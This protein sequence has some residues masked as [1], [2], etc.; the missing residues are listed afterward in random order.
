MGTRLLVSASVRP[1]FLALILSLPA[2][3]PSSGPVAAPRPPAL[4]AVKP[5]LWLTDEAARPTPSLPAE[6][7]AVILLDERSTVVSPKGIVTTTCRR[8]TRVLRPG[9]VEL[10]NRLALVDTYDSKVRSMTGWVINPSG[11]PREVTMKQV[12]SSSITP[13]TLYMDAKFMLL[14]VPEVDVG[15]VVGFEWE[16]RRTQP[17]IE[18][19]YEFQG[20]LPVLR[21]CYSL[22][23][24][25]G[26]EPVF[27][28]VNWPA[29]AA[30]KRDPSA[31]GAISFEIA[32]IPAIAN[33]PYRPKDRA[34]GGRLLVRF[35]MLDA[36]LLSFADWTDMG[37]WYAALSGD[38]RLPDEAVS[39]KARELTAAAPDT[40]SKI[41]ALAEFAQKEIRYVSI[42]IGIGGLQPHPAPGVLY[43]RYGDCKDK[44][45]LLAA[46]LQA[47]GIDSHYI[48][49]HT[50]RGGVNLKSPVSLGSF[51]HVI[52]AI[53]LPDDVPDTDLDSVVRHPG[54]GRLIVFDPTMPT[55][56][57]GR[58]PYYLQDNTGL[59][60][61]GGGGELLVL[62]RP[63]P[64]GN[65]LDRRG[66]LVL[67][68]DGAL[69]GEITE[70]RRGAEADSL[71]YQIQSATEAERRKYLETFLSRS[72]ASFSLETYE[73]K[74]LEDAR[75][76]LVVSYSFI[77]SAYAKRAG[78]YLVVRP[79]VVGNKAV[80]LASRDKKPRRYPIDL[81]TTSFSQDEFTIELPVGWTADSLPK[82]VALDAGFASY[83]SRTEAAGPTLVY[84]RE[85]R[86]IDPLLPA[87]RHEEALKFFLA[88]GAEE[89][90][91]LLL[92]ATVIRRP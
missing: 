88:V 76:D 84:R 38:R 24:P 90:Q 79:R 80:D 64:G 55:T 13:D 85:Y 49:I 16:E 19:I 77:A 57:L 51:N 44:A 30:S 67:T 9:G 29:V 23:A 48:I 47:V 34:L 83:S 92:K 4:G 78:G 40:F 91:S 42:Q 43:N 27:S 56:P 32:D 10:A 60:V 37:A 58:L 82:P 87:S 59:L 46:M 65:V 54:L 53:R 75:G 70:T 20:E 7:E 33:E 8:A 15:S 28:W 21:T 36:T 89:Q 81:E 66:R 69:A 12:I 35:A 18:D 61:A 22:F 2:A 41:R 39:K 11:S 62:P 14:A 45:T 72:F 31:P 50:D 63:G 52:L 17:T 26:W 1:F 5:P 68:S 71:R 25:A 86:L 3:W 74:N 6:T 73:F